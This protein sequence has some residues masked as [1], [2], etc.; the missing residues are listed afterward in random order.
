MFVLY[1]VALLFV[2]CVCVAHQQSKMKLE[3]A[4]TSMHDTPR[5]LQDTSPC[6]GFLF[7]THTLIVWIAATTIG[8]QSLPG[9]STCKQPWF[10]AHGATRAVHIAGTP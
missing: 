2:G 4:V 5:L 10:V 1:S 8:R 6:I 3:M 9:S 7:G